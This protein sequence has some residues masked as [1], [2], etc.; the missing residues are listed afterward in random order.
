MAR[1]SFANGRWDSR[2]RAIFRVIFLRRLRG[3]VGFRA[4]FFLGFGA[5]F[6]LGLP[7][8]PSLR[9]NHYRPEQDLNPAELLFGYF[10]V[11]NRRFSNE[12]RTAKPRRDSSSGP[13]ASKSLV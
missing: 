4:A 5:S 1:D 6:L 10:F 7:R 12:D 2:L 11:T 13:R 9:D 3:F 8:M